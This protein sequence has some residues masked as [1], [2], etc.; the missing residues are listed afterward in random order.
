MLRDRNAA[1]FEVCGSS[2]TVNVMP[3]GGMAISSFD[4]FELSF[5][6]IL[7]LVIRDDECF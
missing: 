1:H 7:D 4:R 5:D 2:K 3:A 6:V